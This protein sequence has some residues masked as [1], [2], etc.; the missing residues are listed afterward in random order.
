MPDQPKQ[1]RG[2]WT[3]QDAAALFQYIAR[4]PKFIE[5]LQR[6]R[7]ITKTDGTMDQA[8]LSG[9]TRKGEDNIIDAIKDMQGDQGTS[10]D[11]A[12]FFD[13]SKDT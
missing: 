8:G 13:A 1:D 6:R 2:Q 5:E 11:A 3:D 7:T 10:V 12:P 9:A 4:H